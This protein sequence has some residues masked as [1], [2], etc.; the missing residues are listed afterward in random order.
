VTVS[1][2]DWARHGAE[3]AVAGTIDRAKEQSLNA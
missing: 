1:R 3:S 2:G